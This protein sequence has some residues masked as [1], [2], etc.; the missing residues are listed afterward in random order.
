MSILDISNTQKKSC[1]KFEEKGRERRETKR[2]KE[3]KYKGG[4]TWSL[5][6]QR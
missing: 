1:L 5:E 2:G 4:K 3:E 6:I